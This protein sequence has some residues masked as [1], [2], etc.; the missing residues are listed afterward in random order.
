M[1]LL[2][3]NKIH[4]LSGLTVLHGFLRCSAQAACTLFM[5]CLF[6]S[7]NSFFGLQVPA[8]THALRL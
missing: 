7:L 3:I 8:G 6:P 5:L 2:A 1:S 4:V